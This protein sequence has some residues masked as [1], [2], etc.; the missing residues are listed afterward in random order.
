VALRSKRGGRWTSTSWRDWH[1]ASN[2]ISATLVGAG[3][4]TGDRVALL[5]GT[6]EEWLI[7]DFGILGAG[8]VTVPIY[9]TATRDQIAFVLEHSGA[10]WAFVET[11]DQLEELRAAANE[12]PALE[13]VVVFDGSAP[14]EPIQ[15][16]SGGSVEVLHYLDFMKQAMTLASDAEAQ[17]ALSVRRG[18]LVPEAL[19]TIVYTSGTTGTPRGAMLTHANLL[20]E[21][22]AINDAIHVGSDDEHLSFLP[23]AHIFARV[24]ALAVVQ[25][26]ARTAFAEGMHRVIDNF[27]EVRPTFFASVPRL[28]EKVFAVANETA[29]A[30]GPVK[31]RLWRWSIGLGLQASRLKQ[32]GEGPSALLAARLRY[33]QKIA[34]GKVRERFGGR[35]RFAVS[36]GAP[37]SRELAEWFHAV[38]ILVVEGYGLTE[39]SGCSHVNRLDRYRFGSVGLPVAGVE[40]QL[41]KDGEVLLRGPTVMQGFYR[42]PEATR[43]VL[44]D[45]GWLH[46]GDIGELD[47]D[48]FLT[49]V[50][51]KKDLIV[52]A[53]GSNVAPQNI[54][55]MLA[56]S[57]WISQAVVF[58][59]RERYLVALLTL[60]LS[61]V[62]RWA[63]DHRRGTDPAALARDPEL[64]ALIQLDVDD[65]NRRLSRF[66]QIR[67]FTILDRE[68]SV[69]DGELTET[70]KPRRDQIRE[71]HAAVIRVMYDASA[72]FHPPPSE[73]P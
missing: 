17:K 62:K 39:A 18:E 48:G 11:A 29:G 66:E 53:G 38:G 56:Q 51:R 20:A 54:E 40:T 46:T 64:R 35:L 70:L 22:S 3:L 68:L 67:K 1:D 19:A 9:P 12:V 71:R 7:V 15:R 47:A 43:E 24:V 60:D 26:G 25:A 58:G 31:E 36:G 8:A 57:P 44:D 2:A 73:P 6:R 13:R 10:R 16:P 41:G 61:T 21:S 69:A 50:D 14:R 59:D 28:F 45:E 27:T 63:A 34:L 23:L 55:R 32:K 5:S 33:A 30:E 65:M 42:Q 4:G 49:I 37:L 72:P 52:T